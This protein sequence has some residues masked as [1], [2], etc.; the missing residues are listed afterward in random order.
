M[1]SAATPRTQRDPTELELATR[2][3]RG[4]TLAFEV[5]AYLAAVPTLADRELARAAAS[6]LGDEAMHWAVLRH[7][8][9][10][11]PVPAAFVG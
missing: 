10:E 2:A 6:I 5:T 4:D 3:A 7:A 1:D 11:N 8:L 9:G